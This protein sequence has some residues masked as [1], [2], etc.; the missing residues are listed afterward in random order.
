MSPISQGTGGSEE[1]CRHSPPLLILKVESLPLFSNIGDTDCYLSLAVLAHVLEGHF[2]AEGAGGPARLSNF[3]F[4]D[5][6]RSLFSRLSLII[7]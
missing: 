4:S 3:V 5:D 7:E 2:L 1:V 6:P